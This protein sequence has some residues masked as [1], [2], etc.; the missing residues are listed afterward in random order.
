MSSKEA[1]RVYVMEQVLEGKLTIKLA[2]E[3]LNLSERQVKRLKE[4]MK[5][6]G[7][8]WVNWVWMINVMS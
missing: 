4:G 6:M 7:K 5:E 3:H 2:A 8:R 1:R